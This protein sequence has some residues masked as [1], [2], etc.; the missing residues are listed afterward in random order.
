MLKRVLAHYG[1]LLRA[2]TGT[3]AHAENYG[4][5]AKIAEL[6]ALY[7]E[8]RALQPD[9][10]ALKGF[11]VFSQTDEDGILEAIFRSVGN[12][13]TFLEIGVEDGTECNTHYLALQGWRGAWVEAS[14]AHAAS[15]EAGLGG[16]EF[17]GRFKLF[18]D[19]ARTDNITR[20]YRETC[21]FVGQSDLD[22]FSL[23]I[24]G[25]DIYVL[26]A[27]LR[28]GARP[29][30][31][32]LEYN[33]KFPP[34]VSISVSRDEERVWGRDD[35]F[36]ASLR[37]LDDI[38]TPYDYVL[39][40]CNVPGTNAFYVRREKSSDLKMQSLEEAWQPI[41]LHLTP[42]PAGHRPTLKYM[43]DAVTGVSHW[44]EQPQL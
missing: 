2:T 27:L 14:D 29:S 38:L 40:T 41:R 26:S 4:Y 37:A 30:V 7:D 17:T 10:L 35:Y 3:S 28:E 22:L 16:R 36:G 8:L 43:R 6:R 11:K 20:I 15:I 34:T 1:T 39:L 32:C 33:G 42:L 5:I 18:N 9:S 12:N 25:N 21:D 44:R 24:D 23:D 13:R 31:I 19:F